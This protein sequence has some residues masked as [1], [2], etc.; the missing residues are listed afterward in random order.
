M[1]FLKVDEKK[2]H[3]TGKLNKHVYLGKTTFIQNLIESNRIDRKFKTIYY[4]YPYHLC[5]APVDWDVR[6][7]DI[8]V[9]FMTELPDARFFETAEKHSLVVID[10]LWLQCCKSNDIVLAFQVYSRKKNISLIIV[11]QRY[12]GGR[13]GGQEIRN[14][15]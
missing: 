3:F 5:E 13:D 12:F 1:S 7:E 4:V 10:D 9:E 2:F 11:S 8:N 6:F 15:W 14:N